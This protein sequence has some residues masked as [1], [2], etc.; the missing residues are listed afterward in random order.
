MKVV[1]T[2]LLVILAA[3]VLAVL[4]GLAQLW[5]RA[6]ASHISDSRASNEL[7]QHPRYEQEPA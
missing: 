5:F 2:I 3:E 1:T 7:H 4:V 6:A